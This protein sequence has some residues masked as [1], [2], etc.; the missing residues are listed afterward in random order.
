M[1]GLAEGDEFKPTQAWAETGVIVV[2]VDLF[3]GALKAVLVAE[4]VA[5]PLS[6]C[7]REDEDEEDRADK[8]SCIGSMEH[9]LIS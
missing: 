6:D 2:A 7:E 8:K 5:L 1:D 4:T 3:A 9:A